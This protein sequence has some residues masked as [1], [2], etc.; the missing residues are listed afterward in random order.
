MEEAKRSQ[1][2]GGETLAKAAVLAQANSVDDTTLA[3]YR[4]VFDILDIAVSKFR[5]FQMRSQS[6]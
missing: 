1:D 3:L 6:N 4:E 5:E 2:M